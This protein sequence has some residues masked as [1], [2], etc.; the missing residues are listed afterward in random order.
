MLRGGYKEQAIIDQV[1]RRHVVSMLDAETELKLQ[2]SGAGKQLLVALKDKRNVLSAQQR[3]A[4]NN[5]AADIDERTQRAA[6]SRQNEAQEQQ[7]V[8]END[9]QRKQFLL[10]QTLQNVRNAERREVSY[11]QA[12]RAYKAQKEALEYRIS[13]LQTRINESRSYGSNESQLR[14]ANATLD[15]YKEELRNLTPPLR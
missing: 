5:F 14:N 8:A 7:L 15:R 1:Q 9:R 6:I 11:Q 12:D 2:Q 3:E 4:H 13:S 10:Q